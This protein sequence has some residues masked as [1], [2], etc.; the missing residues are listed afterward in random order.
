[1]KSGVINSHVAAYE[2]PP[3]RQISVLLVDDD[4][5]LCSL[6]SEYFS[7]HECRFE[8]AHDGSRGLAEALRSAYDLVILDVML[9][10]L[11]GFKVLHQLR[12]TSLVP[13]IM[14]TARTH[15]RD[16]IAGLDAGADDYLMKPFG[17]DELLA[18][19]HAVLRRS[20]QLR[21]RE[22]AIHAADIDLDLQTRKVL[23]AHEQVELTSIEFDILSLLMRSAGRILS[24]DEIA[25][26]LYQRGATSF[27]RSL[28]VHIC[29]L[30]KKLE[31]SS[32]TQIQTVRGT[33]YLFSFAK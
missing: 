24:R 26:A 23:V 22:D 11:D 4:V 27:E 18:R 2:Q 13:V 19:I 31:R 32:Q 6:M 5:E 16:R 10:L 20:G 15:E 1:M 7:Q 17:P 33:G 28:D 21:F 3:S 30:R 12:R 29:H 14:L 25:A 8:C 9:P